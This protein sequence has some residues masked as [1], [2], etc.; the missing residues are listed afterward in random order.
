MVNNDAMTSE[1]TATISIGRK[2]VGHS[3]ALHSRRSRETHLKG[4]WLN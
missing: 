2:K 4:A 3:A 1:T